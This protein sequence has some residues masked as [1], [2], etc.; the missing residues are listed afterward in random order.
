MSAEPTQTA[1]RFELP[2]RAHALFTT[3]AHGNLSTLR[4]PG[5][6]HGRAERDRLCSELGLRWLCASRQVHSTTVTRIRAQDASAGEPLDLDADGHATALRGVGMTVLVADCLPVLLASSE[7]VAAIHAGWRGLAA[8]II[9]EGVAA[10]RELGGSGELVALIGPGAG[11]CCYEVGEEVHAAFDG[12]GRVGKRNLDLPSLARERLLAAGV[13]RVELA[14]AC[15][16][17]DTS[18]YSHR[19]DRERAGRQAGVVWLN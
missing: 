1:D 17:C 7:A 13:D 15:T 16:I 19:R 2:G 5:A 12:A 10:V 9:E 18:L 8:G 6:E 14:G 4:G 11:P 3:R